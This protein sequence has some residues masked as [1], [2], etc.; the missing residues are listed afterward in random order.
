MLVGCSNITS[1]DVSTHSKS[2][3]TLFKYADSLVPE[4]YRNCAGIRDNQRY[5]CCMLLRKS[6]TVSWDKKKALLNEAL[7]QI[8]ISG[9]A[10]S[11]VSVELLSRY[12]DRK[13]LDSFLK[14]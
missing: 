4:E 5:M 2:V 9:L 8:R 10:D 12:A 6:T 13:R 1:E 7:P 14:K 3:E 11:I